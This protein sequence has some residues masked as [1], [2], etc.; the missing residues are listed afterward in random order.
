M[1]CHL[2]TASPSHQYRRSKNQKNADNNKTENQPL[3][4][5]HPKLSGFCFTVAFTQN[6]LFLLFVIPLNLPAR[7]SGVTVS[8]LGCLCVT[9]VPWTHH[10]HHQGVCSPPCPPSVPAC[11]GG[12]GGTA[13]DSSCAQ[14]Q[15]W[16]QLLCDTAALGTAEGILQQKGATGR[17]WKVPFQG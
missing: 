9:P 13:R 12:G 15:E 4:L 17:V 16:A 5:T 6:F 1:C 11:P 10:T 8:T 2:L 14:G 7:H 3:K